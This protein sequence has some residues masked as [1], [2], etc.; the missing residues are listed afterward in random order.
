MKN[1]R[2]ANWLTASSISTSTRRSSPALVR[3]KARP[4]TNAANT[5]LTLIKPETPSTRS[6]NS[7]VNMSTG[8]FSTLWWRSE[9]CSALAADTPATTPT[10]RAPMICH[11]I[12]EA[13]DPAVSG[14]A[15][16]S[17]TRTSG[18]ASPSLAPDSRDSNC[19]SCSGRSFSASS[20]VT[21]LEARTGS[22][23]QIAVPSS[24]A[25]ASGSP[26]VHMAR[27]VEISAIAGKA[28][29]SS[30]VS[31]FQCCRIAEKG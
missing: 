14:V 22:V 13:A 5:P 19:R 2:T 18:R 29:T 26:T 7:R 23:G 28:T 15:T 20:P 11:P 24:R 4:A 27:P 1:G 10:T 25:A 30:R 12:S 17:A 21:A 8:P 16:T 9:K 31:F 3:L 6:V